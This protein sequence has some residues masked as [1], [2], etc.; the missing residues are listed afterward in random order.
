MASAVII[1]QD[2]KSVLDKSVHAFLGYFVGSWKALNMI[3]NHIHYNLC[4]NY[5]ASMC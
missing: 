3:V 5:A 4:W 2:I 1:D